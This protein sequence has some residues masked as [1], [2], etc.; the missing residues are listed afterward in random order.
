MVY[1]RD[2]RV[3]HTTMAES[4]TSRNVEWLTTL[5]N[6]AEHAVRDIDPMNELFLVRIK[7]KNPV[8]DILVMEEN[9]YFL[10]LVQDPSHSTQS[11]MGSASTVINTSPAG[12]Q[13]G[14]KKRA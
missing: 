4:Q 3:V 2:G 12:G 7:S 13:G 6:M 9:N 1:N 14:Q 10:A 8:Q 5:V 11:T